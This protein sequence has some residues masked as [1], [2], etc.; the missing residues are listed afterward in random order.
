MCTCVCVYARGCT[1]ASS[2]D[3]DFAALLVGD[4][5]DDAAHLRV[6]A[7]VALQPFAVLLGLVAVPV[8]GLLERGEVAV[9]ARRRVALQ[10]IA[11]VLEV[12]VEPFDLPC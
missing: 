5:A 8:G 9:G 4:R 10:V 3:P 6:V 1:R 2:G 7:I 11:R 12:R